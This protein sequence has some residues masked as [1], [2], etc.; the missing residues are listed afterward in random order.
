VI[1]IVI[2][3][4]L[5]GIDDKSDGDGDGVDDGLLYEPSLTMHRTS[6]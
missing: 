5:G 3:R 1:A 4:V 2:L 6:K